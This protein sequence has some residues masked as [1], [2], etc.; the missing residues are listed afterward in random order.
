MRYYN[1]FR[2]SL[3]R[4]NGKPMLEVKLTLSNTNSTGGN[5]RVHTRK[6]L[7]WRTPGNMEITN[8]IQVDPPVSIFNYFQNTPVQIQRLT[9][10]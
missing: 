5:N 8:N 9:I 7:E 4:G 1:G 2:K 6:L 10:P 3:I